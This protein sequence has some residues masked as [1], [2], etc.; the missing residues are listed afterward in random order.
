MKAA[1][2]AFLIGFPFESEVVDLAVEEVFDPAAV[3]AVVAVDVAGIVVP[4]FVV[5]V[6]VVA[7]AAKIFPGGL[8]RNIFSFFPLFPGFSD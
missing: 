5:P 2:E 1:A 3:S 7:V 4:A 6:V 8:S